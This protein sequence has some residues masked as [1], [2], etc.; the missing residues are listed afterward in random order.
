MYQFK[1]TNTMKTIFNIQ[2]LCIFVLC[3]GL[4][5]CS[6]SVDDSMQSSPNSGVKKT[7]A[8]GDLPIMVSTD[9]E[10]YSGDGILNFYSWEDVYAL[11]D[12]WQ[13]IGYDRTQDEYDS[14][15]YHNEIMESILL[16][17][18]IYHQYYDNLPLI[19]NPEEEVDD[20]VIDLAFES[21][22]LQHIGS[23]LII[24]TILAPDDTE[25]EVITPLGEL[26]I[27]A[28]CNHDG[29]LIVEGCLYKR[30]EDV[31]ISFDDSELDAV[32]QITTMAELQDYMSEHENDI[33][34]E[35][36]KNP[37]SAT[38]AN[39]W[40]TEEYW[41][42]INGYINQHKVWLA[43]R[44][45]WG[46]EVGENEIGEYYSLFDF[47]GGLNTPWISSRNSFYESSL[48][49]TNYRKKFT[50]RFWHKCGLPT[51]LSASF[52]TS[53]TYYL[54]TGSLSVSTPSPSFNPVYAIGRK[55]YSKTLRWQSQP[56]NDRVQLSD[57][58]DHHLESAHISFTNG[59]VSLSI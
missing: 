46:T 15:G 34:I 24:D 23:S 44:E 59:R 43:L 17:D 28:L 1:L 10:T 52:E 35:R 13:Q 16:Y 49:I 57:L 27:F 11:L 8:T 58:L 21:A 31:I 40:T 54:Y 56:L 25:L 32:G 22:L 36:Y 51:N 4:F 19:Y 9:Y 42:F 45:R 2:G 14:I 41:Y 6:N 37:S 53:I 38:L 48:T 5:A 18:G 55:F 47:Y 7:I 3:F 50:Q 20:D 39:G 12:R 30:I 26:D 29:Y 33:V